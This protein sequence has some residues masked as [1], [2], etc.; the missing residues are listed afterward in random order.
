MEQAGIT[1][2][3]QALML[4]S[5]SESIRHSFVWVLT[6]VC[7]LI[8]VGKSHGALVSALL[9]VCIALQV[10]LMNLRSPCVPVLYALLQSNC[11]C[12]QDMKC[13]PMLWHVTL[14]A[15]AL[16]WKSHSSVKQKHLMTQS[17]AMGT[18]LL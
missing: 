5:C 8:R 4:I 18:L 15:K 10:T 17:K 13:M 11:L 2:M 3:F 14:L 12:L 16:V 1:K 6:G 9:K 7:D